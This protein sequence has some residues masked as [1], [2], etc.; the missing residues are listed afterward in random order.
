MNTKIHKASLQDVPTL[1]ELAPQYYAYDG[2]DFNLAAYQKALVKLLQNPDYGTVALV[3]TGS[4]PI[5]YII[6]CYGYSLEFGGR[7]AYID[8][9]FLLQEYRGKGL[10]KEAI[11]F[12]EEEC[13]KVGIQAIHL[14]VQHSNK[15]AYQFYQHIGFE[16]HNRHLMTKK[17]C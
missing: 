6:V 7:D 3:Y 9:V 1:I 2:H 4:F 14:E 5:G 15:S 17:L 16:D 8:E 12:V 11:N 10:G 13:R